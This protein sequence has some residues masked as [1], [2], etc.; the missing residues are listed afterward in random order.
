MFNFIP[1]NLGTCNGSTGMFLKDLTEPVGS[2]N[3]PETLKKTTVSS[4]PTV[5]NQSTSNP[6]PKDS[7]PKHNGISSTQSTNCRQSTEGFNSNLLSGKV[8]FDFQAESSSELSLTTDEIVTHIRRIDA[9]WSEGMVRGHTGMFPAVFVEFIDSP[10]VINTP[11]VVSDTV[12]SATVLY[13]FDAER[14]EEISLYEGQRV[15]VVG[16]SVD[17]WSKVRT[18]FG[19]GGLCPSAFLQ[20]LAD[21]DQGQKASLTGAMLKVEEKVLEEGDVAVKMRNGSISL[22]KH[23]KIAHR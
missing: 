9:E 1:F 22:V 21:A 5:S 11:P 23:G 20:P 10:A 8:L 19:D 3:I 2:G 4:Q 7:L 12:I 18:E 6:S 16:D 15:D 17:D 14:E 13:D